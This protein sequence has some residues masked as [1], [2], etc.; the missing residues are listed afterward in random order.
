MTLFGIA[1][2][3]IQYQ[4]EMQLQSWIQEYSSTHVKEKQQEGYLGDQ[5]GDETLVEGHWAPQEG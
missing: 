5:E 1:G 4:S 3:G 2:L